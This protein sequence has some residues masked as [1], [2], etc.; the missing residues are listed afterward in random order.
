MNRKQG[1]G[2]VGEEYLGA[3]GGVRG[4]SRDWRV[5]ISA[6]CVLRKPSE[7]GSE[8]LGLVSDLR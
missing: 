7:G 3:D 2:H 1:E 5:E 4:E 6:R 8:G